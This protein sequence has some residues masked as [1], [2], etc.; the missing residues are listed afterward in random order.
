MP[1]E[2]VGGSEN[3]RSS[4]TQ[5][6]QHEAGHSSSKA[7]M[8]NKDQASSRD[9]KCKTLKSD[10]IAWTQNR[11][12]GN[13]GL[14]FAQDSSH[15]EEENDRGSANAGVP[16]IQFK[17]PSNYRIPLPQALP[18]DNCDNDYKPSIENVHRARNSLHHQ[19]KDQDQVLHKEKQAE[20]CLRQSQASQD[21]QTGL[22]ETC[23]SPCRRTS[24]QN[25]QFTDRLSRSES[26]DAA[27]IIIFQDRAKNL[28]ESRQQEQ[29][30]PL[31]LIEYARNVQRRS[32]R[33][34]HSW[35]VS[36][37][38]R[39]LLNSVSTHIWW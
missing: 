24:Q 15:E 2:K 13:A 19:P 30:S 20:S 11:R 37:Q 18:A 3:F 38:N 33:S 26:E 28:A 21:S 4:Y 27:P 34:Q 22:Q 17:V 12:E 7:A 36:K 39:M 16:D 31:R 32:L 10:S 35:E 25:M 29:D 23:I 14:D 9:S 8:V 6:R 1:A 5:G